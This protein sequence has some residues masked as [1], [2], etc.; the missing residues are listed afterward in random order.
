MLIAGFAKLAELMKKQ[1]APMYAPTGCRGRAHA[2][3]A[4]ER[5]D[6]EQQPG[7]SDHLRE[8]VRRRGAVM[9]RDTDGGEGEH[10]VGHERPQHT[11]DHLRRDV[12]ERLAPR[13][14]A[15]ARVG[16]RNDGLKCPQETG[17][18]IRMIVNSPA[19]V[20]AAFLNSSRPTPFG[21]SACAATT[22]SHRPRS[23]TTS[24]S[25]AT[26]RSSTP[27]AA[28]L[29]LLLRHHRRAAGAIRHG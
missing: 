5:R 19:A 22:T 2:L 11:A 1:A 23:P 4:R 18:N 9:R 27:S 12:G 6:Q 10:P 26:P 20:A 3:A 21:E 14:A 8:E 24:R 29:G 15:K 17:P 28:D 7:G 25:S 13:D 16:E